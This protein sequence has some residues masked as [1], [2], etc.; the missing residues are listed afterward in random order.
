[1]GFAW[2]GVFSCS[3][4][5]GCSRRPALLCGPSVS[6]RAHGA[7]VI[8][9]HCDQSE[10]EAE[11]AVW[12]PRK[13]Q[14]YFP[15]N[16]GDPIAPPALHRERGS[17]QLAGL[18]APGDRN[19]GQGLDPRPRPPARRVPASPAPHLL[20]HLP[21]RLQQL[22]R[23]PRPA[24]VTWPGVT[25]SRS[26]AE[27]LTAG[28]SAGPWPQ[29]DSALRG[30]SHRLLSTPGARRPGSSCGRRDLETGFVQPGDL[31]TPGGPKE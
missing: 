7:N 12:V 13:I 23:R 29:V 17:R 27:R 10:W 4:G 19:L 28:R 24:R 22:Y 8:A 20:R 31:G 21:P 9:P 16:D 11:V 5:E 30:L 2:R 25:R 6:P 26:P 15:D 1:M 18:P 3:P 14:E